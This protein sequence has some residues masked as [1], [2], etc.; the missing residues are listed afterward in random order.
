MVLS[1]SGPSPLRGATNRRHTSLGSRFQSSWRAGST[2]SASYCSGFAKCNIANEPRIPHPNTGKIRG[3]CSRGV[4]CENRSML[5]LKPT[6]LG[7]ANDYEARDEKRRPIGRN[8]WTHAALQRS[9]FASSI[10]KSVILT[11]PLGQSAGQSLARVVRHAFPL[12]EAVGDYLHRRHGRVAQ[13]DVAGDVTAYAFAL[14]A[15]HVA[16]AFQITNDPVY[17]VHRRTGD[18]PDQRIHVLGRIACRLSLSPLSV[19]RRDVAPDEITDLTLDRVRCGLIDIA[20]FFGWTPVRRSVFLRSGFLRAGFLWRTRLIQ[21]KL[22][23]YDDRHGLF[24]HRR[25]R[26]WG[27]LSYFFIVC[28]SSNFNAVKL[29]G[30]L[31][32]SEE[33]TSE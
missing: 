12:C 3:L 19:Q 18:A 23:R 25:I 28:S 9:R 20:R 14:V 13:A 16:H 7:Q 24:L 11:L 26:C 33:H 2:T 5:K 8:M 27:G 21:N 15:Q 17:F 22:L 1:R 6:G 31:H 32:R 30:L 29:F 4:P 10:F